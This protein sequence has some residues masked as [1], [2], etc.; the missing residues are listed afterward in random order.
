MS[1]DEQAGAYLEEARL[2]LSSAR[3]IYSVAEQSGE[4]LW[5]QVVKNGYDAIEQ[6]ISAALAKSGESIPRRHPAKVNEFIEVC[7]PGED[8]EETLLYWLGRR[9]DSQYVDIRGETVNV[10]HEQFTRQDA[11]KIIHDAESMIGWIDEGYEIR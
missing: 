9:S 7:Q 5:A 11:E 6:A 10:P 3:A 4:N 2:T 1:S 8:L